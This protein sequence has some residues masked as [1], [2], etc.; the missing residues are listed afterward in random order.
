MGDVAEGLRHQFLAGVP[1]Y[2]AQPLIDFQPVSI[3]SDAGDSDGGVL[4]DAPEPRLAVVER[5]NALLTLAQ[6]LCFVVR[7]PA[8][9]QASDSIITVREGLRPIDRRSRFITSSG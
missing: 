1:D 9:F 7:P 2:V 3:R 6:A 8:D 4:K 5:L